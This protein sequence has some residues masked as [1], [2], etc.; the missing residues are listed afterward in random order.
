ME[1]MEVETHTSLSGAQSSALQSDSS[2][3][4]EEA[5]TEKKSL[6][7]PHFPLR[8]FLPK[9]L[10]EGS[11]STQVLAETMYWVVVQAAMETRRDLVDGKINSRKQIKLRN[12][13]SFCTL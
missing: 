1:G 3:L 11:G 12:L 10:W 9:K 6:E 13:F 2:G 5:V 7:L 8:V 4:E